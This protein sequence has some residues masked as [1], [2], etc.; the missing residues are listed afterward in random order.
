[1]HGCKLYNHPGETESYYYFESECRRP[2]SNI[3]LY[4]CHNCIHSEAEGDGECPFYYRLIETQKTHRCY[5]WT[6][7]EEPHYYDR[8]HWTSGHHKGDETSRTSGKND[9]CRP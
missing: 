5:T 1:M 8:T 9:N 2:S 3:E 7:E 6:D 4:A